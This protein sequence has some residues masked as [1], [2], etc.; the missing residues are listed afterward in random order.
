MEARNCP[1]SFPVLKKDGTIDARNHRRAYL[2]TLSPVQMDVTQ[3]AAK[4]FVELSKSQDV[5]AGDG[6]T[7]GRICSRP[8]QD[9]QLDVDSVAGSRECLCA[10]GVEPPLHVLQPLFHQASGE[11]CCQLMMLLTTFS[12]NRYHLSSCLNFNT[13]GKRNLMQDCIPLSAVVVLAGALLRQSLNLLAKG[14]HP[15][16]ISEALHK[17]SDK[18][19]EVGST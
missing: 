3:P 14:V 9:Q 19:V 15:T 13:D 17:A 10:P 1:S 8:Q 16:V 12:L 11:S 5:V 18:A 2:F 7:S 4:M 6:T